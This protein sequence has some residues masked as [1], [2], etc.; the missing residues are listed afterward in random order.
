MFFVF[1]FHKTLRCIDITSMGTVFYLS[2]LLPRYLKNAKGL[3]DDDGR[4]L[5]S[6]CFSTKPFLDETRLDRVFQLDFHGVKRYYVSRAPPISFPYTPSLWLILHPL[7]STPSS[8]WGSRCSGTINISGGVRIAEGDEK[9]SEKGSHSLY[10]LCSI[11]A[12]L[13]PSHG[14]SSSCSWV[15]ADA[16][17]KLDTMAPA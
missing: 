12:T 3:D 14:F 13:D 17:Y 1:R 8:S 4:Q 7:L 9:T 10:I 5:N 16:I 15:P 2:L 6:L 11:F